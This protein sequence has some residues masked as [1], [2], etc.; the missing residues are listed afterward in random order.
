[1]DLRVGMKPQTPKNTLP[2]EADPRRKILVAIKVGDSV[3]LGDSSF[4]CKGGVHPVTKVTNTQIVVNI[5][6]QHEERFQRATGYRIGGGSF[7][8]HIQGVATDAEIKAYEAKLKAEA[9]ERQRRED[10]KNAA[11]AKRKGLQNHF[12]RVVHVGHNEFA[13][14]MDSTY[15]VTIH[16]LTEDAVKDLASILNKEFKG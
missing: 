9:E 11:E 10:E 16:G 15:S 12:V 5:N 3:W 14:K 8:T 6:A 1:M 13:E 4:P 2:W 7:S